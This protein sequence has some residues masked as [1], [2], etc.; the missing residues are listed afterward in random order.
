M[1]EEPGKRLSLIHKIGG[2]RDQEILPLLVKLLENYLKVF[3]DKANKTRLS[4]HSPG[5]GVSNEYHY[6]QT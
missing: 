6:L 1:K 3:K 2:T 5:V 4:S